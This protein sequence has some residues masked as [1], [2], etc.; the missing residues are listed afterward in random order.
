VSRSAAENFLLN[1]LSKFR[2]WK[3]AHGK[4]PQLEFMQ[5]AEEYPNR[6]FRAGNR[7]GKTTIGAVDHLLQAQCLHPFS[8]WNKPT[9][10]WIITLDNDHGIG[11][12]IWPAMKPWLIRHEL[13][14]D[15]LKK[16]GV[17]IPKAV[18]FPNGSEIHF[19]SAEAKREKFQGAAKVSWIW[20]DEEV[21]QAVFEESYTRLADM[22]GT[23]AVT[24][25]P[26]SRKAWIRDLERMTY[27]GKPLTK[28]VRASMRDAALAGLLDLQR[29]EQILGSLPER[30]RRVRELGDFASVEG[31][32]WPEFSRETHVLT[33]RGN[34]LYDNNNRPLYS[35][36]LPKYWPRIAAVDFGYSNP[37]AVI[38]ACQDP[39]TGRVIVENVYYGKGMTANRWGEYLKKA[40]PENLE[41][42]VADHDAFQRAELASCGLPTTPAKKDVVPGIEAVDRFMYP[43]F[44]TGYP[45]LMFVMHDEKN[46][47]PP[48]CDITASRC[49]SHFLLWEIEG[50]RYPERREN[51]T[52][53]SKDPKDVPLKRDDHACDSLRYLVMAVEQSGYGAAPEIKGLTSPDLPLDGAIPPSPW[54]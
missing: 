13:K 33:P 16:S 20:V 36:P 12:I 43:D 28:V 23:V 35:W 1:P 8:R 49:D 31:L 6:I 25:T 26:L 54:R 46:S 4:S 51:K 15:W 50:Y 52:G 45:R 9:K 5:A 27:K 24:L 17:E 48:W 29:V 18:F 21:D 41:F 30:Q 10:G 44:D 42:F 19:L 53:D 38:L 34:Q 32:V 47:I 39:N 11:Q 14:I 7:S 22:G 3:T 2:P 37:T 40:L